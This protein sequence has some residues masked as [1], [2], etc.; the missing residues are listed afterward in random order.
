MSRPIA[1]VHD[2]VLLPRPFTRWVRRWDIIT[3]KKRKDRKMKKSALFKFMAYFLL[4]GAITF[5]EGCGSGYETV[6]ENGRVYIQ[7]KSWWKRMLF[8]L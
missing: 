3:T 4:L 6:N 1:K 7:R 5:V 8:P 2:F